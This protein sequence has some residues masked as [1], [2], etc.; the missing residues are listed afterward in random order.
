ML[1]K[2]LALA[3]TAAAVLIVP[4]TSDKDDSI[5]RTLPIEVDTFEI[6]ETAYGQ[7]VDVPCLQCRGH[8]SQLELNFGIQDRRLVLNGFELYPHAD[9]WN[10]DLSAA[11]IKANGKSDMRRL[12]YGLAIRPEGVDEDQHL[13]VVNVEVRIIEVGDRFVDG[14]PP[15]IVKLI[16]APVGEIIIG[17]IEV[18][19][20]GE[21]APED[22]DMWCRAK[23]MVHDTWKDVKGKFKGKGCLGMKG[24]GKGHGHGR[25]PHHGHGKGENKP[26]DN[27]KQGPLVNKAPE[28]SWSD[29]FTHVTAYIIIPVLMGV[30]AG[31][32]VA[33]FTMF[34]CAMVLRVIRMFKG[35]SAEPESEFAPGAAHKAAIAEMLVEDEKSGLMVDE[36]ALPQY[37]PRN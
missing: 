33:F 36:E 34:L 8:N 18:K 2:P 11:V 30:A 5:F 16:K 14:V 28:Q 17:S 24:K 35:E 12:G 37:E 4:E 32:G 13:E 3:A 15:V 29:V 1:F 7:V 21:K 25:K 27:F 26:T 23:G 22:C 20:D 6:P 10:G 19:G 31:V 9:P